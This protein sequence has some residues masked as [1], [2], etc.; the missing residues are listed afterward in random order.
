LDGE[1]AASKR[2]ANTKAV[3]LTFFFIMFSL[4]SE[5]RTP[6][7]MIFCPGNAV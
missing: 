4:L 1:Q 3:T 6:N 7:R 2:V 5:K